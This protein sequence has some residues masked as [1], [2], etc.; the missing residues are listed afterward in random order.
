MNI[1]TKLFK[2]KKNK[3]LSLIISKKQFPQIKNKNPKFIKIKEVEFL[4]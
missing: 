4:E 2:N 3:Q 1:I